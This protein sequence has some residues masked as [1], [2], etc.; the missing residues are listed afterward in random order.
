MPVAGVFSTGS[1]ESVTEAEWEGERR[2]GRLGCC[3][4]RHEM[5]LLDTAYAR[6]E[7]EARQIRGALRWR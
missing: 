1:R 2:E 6:G 3:C 5:Y 4:K 7:E